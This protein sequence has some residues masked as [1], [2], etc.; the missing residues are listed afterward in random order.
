MRLFRREQDPIRGKSKKR[1]DEVCLLKKD[2]ER[3]R[4]ALPDLLRGH[5]FRITRYRIERHLKQCAICKSE[6]DALRHVEETSRLLKD[7]DPPEGVDHLVKEGVFALAKLKKI[8]YRP[9]WLAGIVLAVAGIY[10]YAMLP[11]QLDIEIENIMGTAPVVTS[12]TSSVSLETRT[13]VAKAKAKTKA[14]AKAKAKAKTK[15]KVKTKAKTKRVQKHKPQP[16]S[17]PAV[18]PLAVS[19]TPNN[20]NSAIKRINRVMGEHGRLRNMKFSY[21]EQKLSGKMTAP[22]LRTFFDRIREV[23]KVRYNRKVFKSFPVAQKIPFVLTLKAA[24]KAVETP[25]LVQEPIRSAGT[26][27]PGAT[28][29]PASSVSPAEKPEGGTAEVPR[30]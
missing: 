29:I 13:T 17:A 2:C 21:V 12:P 30:T 1:L 4:K 9:L 18:Q 5:V 14:K 19:I 23:S 26:H 27:T 11:R 15:T 25:L 22:E 28:D 8:F 24:P 7:I 3:T 16:V 6:F 10:Y 20:E